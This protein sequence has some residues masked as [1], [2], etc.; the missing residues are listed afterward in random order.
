M[1][2]NSAITQYNKSYWELCSWLR[3]MIHVFQCREASGAGGCSERWQFITMNSPTPVK[4]VKMSERAAMCR[5]SCPRARF[6]PLRLF[7]INSLLVLYMIILNCYFAQLSVCF[8]LCPV[9][10]QCRNSNMYRLSDI[11]TISVSFRE[12]TCSKSVTLNNLEGL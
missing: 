8:H 1:Y 2:T 12:S 9:H 7:C 6:S 3:A 10:S 4:V 5:K 11:H